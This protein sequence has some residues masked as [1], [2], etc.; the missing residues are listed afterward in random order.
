M[1]LDWLVEIWNLVLDKRTIQACSFQCEVRYGEEPTVSEEYLKAVEKC[2]KKLR[3]LITEKN[4]AP[5]MLRIATMK[6]PAE[7][8]HGANAGL[9]IV[10]R[11][12]EPIKEQFPILS[13]AVEV[14]GGPEI[15]FH[16]GLEGRL[17][18]ATKGTD[19]L[20]EIFVKQMGLTD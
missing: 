5:L 1:L 14:T 12:L 18:D 15:P 11:L 2:K 16:P 6:H 19:H 3:G 4:C 20:R 13:Y 8:G 17:P 7:L 9:D 10:V